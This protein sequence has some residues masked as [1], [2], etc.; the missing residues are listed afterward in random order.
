MKLLNKI[1]FLLHIKK[2]ESIAKEIGVSFGKSCRFL[3]DPY[4]MFGTEPYLVWMGN[5]VEVSNGT[6]FVTHDGGLFVLRNMYHEECGKLDK[7]KP[8]QVGNNVYFGFNCLVLPGVKIGN[9]VVVGAGSIVTKDVP[10]NVVVGGVPAMVIETLEEYK[11]KSNI[12]SIPT[13]QMTKKD[14]KDYLKR[15]YVR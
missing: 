13:K 8:I 1:L 15:I 12:S 10:D 4:K 6:R 5:N 9:N 11:N 7:I 2:S 3:D 14:K